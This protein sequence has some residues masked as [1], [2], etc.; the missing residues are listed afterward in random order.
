MVQL[1]DRSPDKLG[2]V[3]YLQCLGETCGRK[4]TLQELKE[5]KG[6]IFGTYVCDN[7][8]NGLD[9]QYDMDFAA[10]R[11]EEIRK[12]PDIYWKVPELL[13]VNSIL[14]DPRRPYTPLVGADRLSDEL[15]IDLYLKLDCDESVNPT[16]TFKDRPMTT[17]T[18]AALEAGYEGIWGASTGNLAVSIGRFAREYGMNARILIPAALSQAKKNAILHYLDPQ[19]LRELNGVYDKA[20]TIMLNEWEALDDAMRGKILIPN[21]SFRPYYKEGSKTNGFEIAF[22]LQ[23]L[24]IAPE[25]TANVIYPVGS[26]A[27]LCSAYK[28]IEQLRSISLATNPARMWAAQAENCAPVVNALRRGKVKS[29]SNG[30]SIE[31]WE[32]IPIQDPKTVAQSIRIGNPGSGYQALDV[33]EKSGGGGWTVSESDII[34]KVL[35]LAEAETFN[36]RPIFGQ[37]V[38]GVVLA[39]IYQGIQTGDIKQGDLVVANITGTGYNRFEDDLEY[40]GREYGFASRVDNLF[41]R[42]GL[43]QRC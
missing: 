19:N 32:I 24:G 36:G 43:K 28:G 41:E 26:G 9:V 2:N 42:I 33:I 15:G 23:Q 10:S 21:A 13:P 7:C 17:T 11:A 8:F 25:R 18:N 31:R 12:R 1:L 16:G 39:G 38:A 35:K 22:Q 6:S 30:D 29:G 14:V 27:L 34:D 4:Y 20:N 3:A 40:Y 37:D 5:T